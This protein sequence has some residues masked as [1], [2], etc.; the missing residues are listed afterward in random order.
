MLRLSIAL[1][2]LTSA[3]SLAVAEIRFSASP[4]LTVQRAPSL[5]AVGDLDDDGFAEVVVGSPASNMLAVLSVLS[6]GSLTPRRNITLGRNLAGL[7]VLDVDADGRNDVLV[8]DASGGARNGDL[9]WLRRTGPLD[10]DPPLVFPLAV[11]ALRAFAAGD[12]DGDG[13]PDAAIVTGTRRQIALSRNVDG[14][15]FVSQPLLER[16][17]REPRGLRAGRFDATGRD[18]LVVINT[19]VNREHELVVL[20]YE[21]PT[22]ALP[23]LPLPLGATPPVDVITGDFNGDGHLDLAVLHAQADRAFYVTTFLNRPQFS[24]PGAT[25]PGSFVMRSPLAFDCPADAGGTLSRCTPQTLTAGDFDADGRVDLMIAVNSPPRLYLLAGLGDGGFDLA[26][27][28]SVGGGQSLGALA[29]ADVTGD[30]VADVVVTDV[31]SNTVT[32]LRAEVPQRKPLGSSCVVGAECVSLACVD[33]VCCGASACASG[34][35]CDVP[36]RVG[37]CEPLAPLGTGCGSAAVCASSFCTDGVCCVRASCG[38]GL[39]CFSD[40]PGQCGVGV[41]TP[42]P[43]RPSVPGATPTPLGS[44]APCTAAGQCASGRCVDAHCCNQNCPA[45]LFC[46]LSGEEGTCRA[47]RFIGEPCAKHDDCVAEQCG[48][49]GLCA[50]PVTPSPTPVRSPAGSLC[51]A[52]G[53]CQTGH[54]TDGVCCYEAACAVGERCDI[55]GMLGDCRPRLDPGATCGRD[56]DCRGDGPCLPTGGTSVCAAASQTPGPIGCYGDCSGDGQV[57]VNEILVL[58]EIALGA[59]AVA[60]CTSG[61]IDGDGQI[62]VDELLTAVSLALAGCS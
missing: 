62:S 30:G 53:D 50:V 51:T 49:D 13:F 2:M 41:A 6:D 32:V 21:D 26:G 52:A 3:P 35:R 16:F 47:R 40:V 8:A 61:D 12:F 60:N 55:T 7:A 4:S 38:P 28:M 15:E 48:G 31:G 34:E 25:S 29:V 24:A 10:F 1:L 22:F 5:L 42:T 18:S 59:Q 56:S 54:C 36:G 45:G 57:T 11:F 27:L 19:N 20:A 33:G 23:G 39:S 37:A 9:L 58:I 14:A 17:E 43:T 44:G 46:N